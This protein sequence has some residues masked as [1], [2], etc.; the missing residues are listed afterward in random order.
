MLHNVLGFGGRM[1]RLDYFLACMALALLTMLLSLALV[2]GF[3]P[4]GESLTYL[5]ESVPPRLIMTLLLVV[6]PFYLWF[7]LAFQAKRI[8]DIGWNPAYVL[9]LWIA[10]VGFD[11]IAA[12]AIPDLAPSAG[13]GTLLG[14]LFNLAL[15]GSGSAYA[16]ADALDA[17]YGKR[18]LSYT[19]FA[20][21]SLGR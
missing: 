9:P 2:L 17:A 7:S 15:G 16:K 12:H 20:K 6:L 14:G 13:G 11:R 10:V 8:R 1:S 5:R 19:L 18:P 21:L 3:K 4:Q